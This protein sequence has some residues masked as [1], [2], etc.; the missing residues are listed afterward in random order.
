MD[1]VDIHFVV[2]PRSATVEAIRVSKLIAEAVGDGYAEAWISRTVGVHLDAHSHVLCIIG[3][4][5]TRADLVT[6]G[7]KM[8]GDSWRIGDCVG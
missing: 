7:I 4:G 3:D 2:P 5:T 8:G 6:D 1:R